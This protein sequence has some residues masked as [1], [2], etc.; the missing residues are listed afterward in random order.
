MNK[1]TLS[2][3]EMSALRLRLQWLLRECCFGAGVDVWLAPGGTCN[4]ANTDPYL[5]PDDEDVDHLQ[6]ILT[7]LT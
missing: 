6:A 2:D 7:K 5:S 4:A 1:I 3:D